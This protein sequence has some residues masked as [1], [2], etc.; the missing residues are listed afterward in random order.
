M[1]G[2][3]DLNQTSA[4]VNRR[5]PLNGWHSG[6]PSPFRRCSAVKYPPYPAPVDDANIKLR[7]AYMRVE[8]SFLM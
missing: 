8:L 7:V 2:I 6:S 3:L 5:T 4:L 1:D